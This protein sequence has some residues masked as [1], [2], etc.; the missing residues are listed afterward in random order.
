[1]HEH[2]R[3]NRDNERKVYYLSKDVQNEMIKLLANAVQAKAISLVIAAKYYSIILDCTPD[4]SHTEKMTV[5]VRFVAIRETTSEIQGHLLG[6]I[7]LTET[8]GASLTEAIVDKLK[9]LELCIDDLRGEG[10]D[11]GSNMT[12][13]H[14][15]VQKRIEE[16][17]PR[18][19]I[20]KR[21]ERW[22]S[23]IDALVPVRYQLGHVHSAL[24]DMYEDRSLKGS[25]GNNSQVQALAKDVVQAIARR[26]PKN[27]N[28]EEVFDFVINNDLKD[29]ASNL[30]MALRILLTL[31]VPVACVLDASSHSAYSIL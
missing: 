1:M 19:L 31:P 18:G 22:E 10:Y 30:S 25:T 9:E 28:P 15:G 24:M 8:T 21:V 5:I 4:I 17:N 12:G 6:F 14:S 7:P 2:L 16:I 13:K 3:K 11:N 29:G 23:Q 27:A 20:P 26:V